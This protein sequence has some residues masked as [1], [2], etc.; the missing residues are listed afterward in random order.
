MEISTVFSAMLLAALGDFLWWLLAD[1][2]LR[3]LRHGWIGR[4]LIAIFI[5]AQLAYVLMCLFAPSQVRRSR[6]PVP[7]WFQTITYVWHIMVLPTLALIGLIRMTWR[8]LTR[9]KRKL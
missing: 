7:M 3:R 8:W 5:G 1:A 4:L 9:Q 2:R 6:G